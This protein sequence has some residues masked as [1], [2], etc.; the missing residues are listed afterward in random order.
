MLA[1]FHWP[2][3][4]RLSLEN[5]AQI[6]GFLNRMKLTL[7]W[8]RGTTCFAVGQLHKYSVS[9]VCRPSANYRNHGRGKWLIL[10]LTPIKNC[11]NAPPTA[12]RHTKPFDWLTASWVIRHQSMLGMWRTPV[13]DR[14]LLKFNLRVLILGRVSSYLPFHPFAL[15]PTVYVASHNG[16]E[17]VLPQSKL[18]SYFSLIVKGSVSLPTLLITSIFNLYLILKKSCWENQVSSGKLQSFRTTTVVPIW[19]KEKD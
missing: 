8:Y 13:G 1:K 15:L 3:T 11:R 10:L 18:V 12:L 16:W 5:K 7:K 14:R 17:Q 6:D 4:N 19:H 2:V 9:Q